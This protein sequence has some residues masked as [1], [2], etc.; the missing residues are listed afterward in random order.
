MLVMYD[1]NV[2]HV[3]KQRQ[4]VIT[5]SDRRDV[6][7]LNSLQVASANANVYFRSN[8]CEPF[9]AL[10]QGKPHVRSELSK[11]MVIPEGRGKLLGMTGVDVKT[12]LRPTF[13]HIKKLAKE[14]AE[15]YRTSPVKPMRLARNDQLWDDHERFWTEVDA[16]RMNPRDFERVLGHHFFYD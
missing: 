7:A 10:Q 14:F 13:V 6:R 3:G 2:Y 5:V 8:A 9:V 16:G 15:Q 11:L 1:T 4:R 12:N